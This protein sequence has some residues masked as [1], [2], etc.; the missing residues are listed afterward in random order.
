MRLFRKF[1]AGCLVCLAAARGFAEQETLPPLVDGRVPSSIDEIWG[2]Y[3]PRQ[4]PLE[5]EVCKEWEEDGVVCRIVRFRVGIFKGKKSVVAGIVAMPKGQQ[6]LPGLVQVHGG[7]QSANSN[8]AITNARRG[9]ACLSLNWGGNPLRDGNYAVIWET[10][11]T[12]WGAVDATHPPQKDPV[13]HFAVNTPNEFTIDAV[14]SPRN[15]AWL[16]V[17]IAVRRAL[18]FLE[19]QSEVDGN[20]LGVYG[21]SMGGK[22]TVMTAAVDARVKAAVPSCGGISDFPSELQWENSKYCQRLKC[23]VMF[24]N[25]VNDFYGHVEDLS[26]AVAGLPDNTWRVV[27][28]PNLNHRD[29]PDHFASGP[30]WFDQHLR[31]QG[32]LPRTPEITLDLSTPQHIPKVTIK[33]DDGRPVQ[34]VEIYYTQLERS[35]ACDN[36][37]WRYVATARADQAWTA[38][39]PLLNIDQPL[40]VFANVRYALE[41]PVAGAGYYYGSYTASEF[42]IS[43]KLLTATPLELQQAGVVAS[44]MPSLTIE[45]FAEGWRHGWYVFDEDGRWPFRTNKVMDPKW[46]GPP[47]AVLM[48]EVQSQQP[49][50][51]VVGMDQHSASRGLTGGDEW[52]TISLSAQDFLDAAEKPLE[53]WSKVCELVLADKLAFR[54]NDTVKVVGDAWKGPLPSFRRLRWELPGKAGDK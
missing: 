19:Q 38:E 3:D 48:L 26:S 4:E 43:S 39:L 31:E 12:D 28:C 33:P 7:G 21:H 18:T 30:V 1:A 46:K 42:V 54:L 47:G 14:D 51:L 10:S 23:P 34:G 36:P 24:L 53:D 50:T 5:T 25:P 41:S 6:G 20:R 16:L 2:D 32:V 8:A 22:L 11:G 44:D 49:N 45:E 37:C 17:T 29:K 13:N 15:S 27:C 9:Y 35:P 52:Q 40:R